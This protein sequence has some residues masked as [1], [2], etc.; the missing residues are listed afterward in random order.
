[1]H[2]LNAKFYDRFRF[3]LPRVTA[4]SSIDQFVQP[5]Q[6]LLW[7]VT[8]GTL[9]LAVIIITIAYTL[10]RIYSFEEQGTPLFNLKESITIIY[11]SLLAQG[12]QAL[13]F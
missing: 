6:L 10:G 1:L 2:F 7:R 5:F 4:S 13:R 12:T 11:G 3:L 9:T 8:A